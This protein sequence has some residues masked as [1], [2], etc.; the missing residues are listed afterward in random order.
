MLVIRDV[1]NQALAQHRQQQFIQEM[2]ENLQHSYADHL[3]LQKIDEDNIKDFVT[4]GIQHARNY[5]IRSRSNVKLFLECM[6]EFGEI[7]YADESLDW[8]VE[9][10]C[11]STL[12]GE[13]KMDAIDE[14]LV[15][16]EMDVS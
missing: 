15:L 3:L 9:I 12:S 6:A 7:F 10:M 2:I 5:E 16:L 8:C 14:S 13:E 4:S 11:D 1:Q